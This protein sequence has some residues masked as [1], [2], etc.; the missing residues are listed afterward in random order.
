MDPY[1]QDEDNV[2]EGYYEER[3]AN[4]FNEK[5][6]KTFSEKIDN[7]KDFVKEMLSENIEHINDFFN[8]EYNLYCEAPGCYCVTTRTLME[9]LFR[10]VDSYHY[11]D[12]TNEMNDKKIDYLA[13]LF[14]EGLLKSE[15]LTDRFLH[16]M[17]QFCGTEHHQRRTD[18]I[19]QHIDKSRLKTVPDILGLFQYSFTRQNYLIMLIENGCNPFEKIEGS[20]LTYYDYFKQCNHDLVVQKCDELRMSL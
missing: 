20:D 10:I 12:E 7:D 17:F 11:G 16:E 3:Q 13:Q 19:L 5:L 4:E 8:E 18:L 14:N 15:V 1:D 2:P 9:R 6:Y